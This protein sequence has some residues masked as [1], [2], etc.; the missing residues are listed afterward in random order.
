MVQHPEK[1]TLCSIYIPA[2]VTPSHP[3]LEALICSLPIPY[4]INGDFNAHNTLWNGRFTNRT[5]KIVEDI[6]DNT[7]LLNNDS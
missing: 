1:C 7:T 6:L 4:L 5:G 3:K 2:D